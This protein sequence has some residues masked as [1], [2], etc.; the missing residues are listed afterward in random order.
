MTD[1][2]TTI[3]ETAAKYR[4]WGKWG[5]ED[6]R[7][8][9]PDDDGRSAALAQIPPVA[10]RHPSAFARG[11]RARVPSGSRPLAAETRRVSSLSGSQPGA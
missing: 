11:T 1:I 9:R 4:N 2:E 7:R 8:I 10:R 3:V 5:A 6:Q